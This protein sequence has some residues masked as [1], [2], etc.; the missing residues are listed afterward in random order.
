MMTQKEIIKQIEA[1][2]IFE[3][4]EI[5]E[6]IQRNI[7]RNLQKQKEQKNLSVEEK[8][9]IVE[10]L[11]GALKMKNPP[12]SKEEERQIIEEHLLEKYQ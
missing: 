10:S 7:K 5:I 8:L 4:F 12:M 2:P 3:Q 9:A 1:F 11:G 6:K